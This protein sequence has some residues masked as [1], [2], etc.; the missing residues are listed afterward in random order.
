LGE[1]SWAGQSHPHED[2][3]RFTMSSE[4]ALAHDRDETSWRIIDD[5]PVIEHLFQ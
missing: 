1:S 3:N 2:G 4:G 5:Q